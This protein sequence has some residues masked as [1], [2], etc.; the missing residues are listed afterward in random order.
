M[1]HCHWLVRIAT[2]D[3]QPSMNLGQAAAVCLWELA[4]EAAPPVAGGEARAASAELERLG[5]LVME[6]LDA[7]DY[8][9]PKT[10]AST[11]AEVRRLLRRLN[12]TDP[13]TH[14]LMGMMRKL[15]WKLRAGK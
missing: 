9:D 8:A 14:L 2:A 15:L 13:D 7:V 3:A 6:L 1:E 10:I 4:R 12:V 5:G 11:E